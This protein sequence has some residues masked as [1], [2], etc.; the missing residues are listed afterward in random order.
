MNKHCLVIYNHLKIVW[1]WL[2]NKDRMGLYGLIIALF[3]LLV[4]YWSFDA[5][6]EALKISKETSKRDS[7]TGILEDKNNDRDSVQQGE[8]VKLLEKY[9]KI[10]DKLLENQIQADRPIIN[11]A[12]I[13]YDDAIKA[14]ILNNGKSYFMPIIYYGIENKGKRDCCNFSVQFRYYFKETNSFYS[15]NSKSMAN[16]I[17]FDTNVK[18]LE[19]PV[20]PVESKND[21]YLKV[22][23]SWEDQFVDVKKYSKEEYI[24]IR[25]LNNGLTDILNAQPNDIKLIKE[26][27]NKRFETK[28]PQ[29]KIDYYL[30]VNYPEHRY[31]TIPDMSKN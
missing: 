9:N 1:K 8:M 29:D 31:P 23:M 11:L 24:R 30:Y 18:P 5:S 12:L 19:C 4:G 13:R 2:L 10:A 28:I 17:G 15:S 22:S 20:I 27:E 16:A 14:V 21:F 26:I 3:S 6:R 7:I 25:K